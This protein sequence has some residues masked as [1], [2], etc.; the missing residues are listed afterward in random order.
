M[1]LCQF[2]LARLD[3]TKIR[4]LFPPNPMTALRICLVVGAPD[5]TYS[6]HAE[7]RSRAPFQR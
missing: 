2:G 4:K 1:Y 3:K 6:G 5:C 7:V